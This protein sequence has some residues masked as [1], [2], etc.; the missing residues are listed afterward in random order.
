[1]TIMAS[2]YFGI[3]TTGGTGSDTIVVAP[4][5]TNNTTTD[6]VATVSINNETVRVTQYGK[7]YLSPMGGTVFIAPATGQTVQLTVHTHY[8]VQF[9]NKPSWITINDGQGNNITSAQTISSSVANGKTYNFVVA[10]NT[11]NDER[12]TSNFGLWHYVK[13]TLQ[14]SFV[15]ISVTQ[16]QGA[17]DYIAIDD[18]TLDWDS[19]SNK[20][21]EIRANVP[22][23]VTN[24]NTADFT[25]TG[26]DG[27]EKIKANAVNSGTTRKTTTITVTST[28]PSFVFST[29]A[30]ITQ[31][32]EPRVSLN[33]GRTVPWSGGTKPVEVVSDYYW[34]PSPTVNPDTN[35]Y[36]DYITMSGKTADQNLA[37]QPSGNTYN[38][39]WDSN[40]GAYTRNGTIKVAYLKNDNTVAESTGYFDFSQDNQASTTFEVVPARLPS[41]VS[42]DRV[43]SGGGVYTLEVVTSRPWAVT[44]TRSHCTVSPSAATGNTIVTVTVPPSNY[45]G[46]TYHTVEGLQFRT[47]DA[48]MVASQM[49]YVYQYD[50]YQAEPNYLVVSPTAATVA[51]T[52]G[53]TSLTVSANTD[54]ALT[55]SPSWLKV[56]KTVYGSSQLVTGGTSGS[57]TIYAHRDENSGETRTGTVSFSAVGVTAGTVYTQNG[58]VTPVPTGY[59]G[60]DPPEWSSIPAR[61]IT[62]EV[63]WDNPSN[64]DYV[65][66]VLPWAAFYDGDDMT[67]NMLNTIP[68]N[69][70]G[71][72]YLIV[73][74]SFTHREGAIIFESDSDRLS[75][76]VSQS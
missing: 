9:R 54:W 26:A 46:T 22:Y 11:G 8:D 64:E 6:R 67:S 4:L 49:V 59:L 40:T 68:A 45:T 55:S 28:K 69:S 24:S 23:T 30:T 43:P 41:N 47:N 63:E 61:G 35:A 18:F 50:H 27:T 60:L 62:L 72:M 48:E 21:L 14:Q 53:H 19:V 31:L 20:N 44:A 37:P 57:T 66:N 10:P 16:P 36:F 70:T 7:P 5:S 2:S 71:T 73:G 51:S 75:F 17:E 39:T 3:N 32:R 38:F 52:S 13:G 74:R 25:L 12:V 65:I 76:Y 42:S 1:M 33:S 34:W 56:R 58:S 15:E 29:S